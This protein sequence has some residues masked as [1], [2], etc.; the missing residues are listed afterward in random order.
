MSDPHHIPTEGYLK[1]NPT[2]ICNDCFKSFRAPGM[3][4]LGFSL[5]PVNH[6]LN[7]LDY[8]CSALLNTLFY[9]ATF[10]AFQQKIVDLRSSHCSLTQ[11]SRET[12]I[13][14]ES[15]IIFNRVLASNMGY[16]FN[17]NY[18]LVRKYI[19]VKGEELWIV[20]KPWER[21][22]NLLFLSWLNCAFLFFFRRKW[23]NPVGLYFTNLECSWLKEMGYV[24]V[25]AKK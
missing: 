22:K 17:S 18:R 19:V 5:F 24:L 15:L 2:R 12:H 21:R 9:L 1:T 8:F 25:F 6:A 11:T 13:L 7:P 16:F 4:S 3:Q 23:K 14:S 20:Y 10:F